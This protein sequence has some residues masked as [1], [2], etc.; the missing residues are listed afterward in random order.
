MTKVNCLQ[1]FPPELPEMIS[2]W[3]KKPPPANPPQAVRPAPPV[4]APTPCANPIS[5]RVLLHAA[6]VAASVETIPSP[7]RH[8]YR[9]RVGPAREGA[10]P[11]ARASAE[12][13]CTRSRLRGLVLAAGSVSRPDGPSHLELL[14]PSE[15]QAEAA[16]ADLGRLGVAGRVAR[17]RGRWLVLVRSATGLATLLSS[18]GAPRARLELEA[19]RV[20]GEVR[21]AV[22]RRLNAETA[23]LRRAAAAAVIQIEAID[24]LRDHRRLWN[25]LPP[26]LREAATVRRRHPQA[27]LERLAAVAGCSRSAMAG[28]LHR[29]LAAADAAP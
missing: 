22:T 12:P 24:R 27:T 16:M 6:G 1:R 10:P 28:R 26:A 11:P 17:R 9:L 15:Q 8:T 20:V 13:C 25:A 14:L 18:L 4:I 2:R 29:L 21:S 23:N 19:G 7:R 5:A 3:R